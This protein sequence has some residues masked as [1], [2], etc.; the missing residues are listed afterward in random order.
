MRPGTPGAVAQLARAPDSNSGR[1]GSTPVCVTAVPD[2]VGT[3]WQS[4]EDDR[5]IQ[6]VARVATDRFVA[7]HQGKVRSKTYRINL[8]TLQGEYRQ[9]SERT[10]SS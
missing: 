4:R 7:H 5:I 2:Y 9:V 1:T 6:L 10:R 3:W 8:Y